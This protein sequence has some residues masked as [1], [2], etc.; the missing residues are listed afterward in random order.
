MLV[1]IKILLDEAKKPFV[2]YVPSNSIVIQGTDKTVEDALNERYT[3]TETDELV[4]TG[5]T[6]TLNSAKAYT[7]DALANFEG[8]ITEAQVDEK[9]NTAKTDLTAAYS[10]ADTTTL[11]SAKSYTDS[12]FD[13]AGSVVANPIVT[14]KEALE[15]QV[16][17]E[18]VRLYNSALRNVSDGKMFT[19]TFPERDI[20]YTDL[21]LYYEYW[22]GGGAGWKITNTQDYSLISGQTCIVQAREADGTYTFTILDVLTNPTSVKKNLKDVLITTC[23]ATNMQYVGQTYYVYDEAL[24]NPTHNQ[25]FI[26]TIPT[27]TQTS[28]V[29]K[30]WSSQQSAYFEGYTLTNAKPIDVSNQKILIQ[31]KVVEDT[32]TFELVNIV[33]EGTV[34]ISDFEQEQEQYTSA[35]TIFYNRIYSTSFKP[36]TVGQLFCLSV[37]KLTEAE[38]YNVIRIDDNSE[39]S[40]PGRGYSVLNAEAKDISGQVVLLRIKTVSNGS[41]LSGTSEIVGIVPKT[42]TSNDVVKKV[43]DF[44]IEKVNGSGNKKYTRFYSTSF[45]PKYVGELFIVQIPDIDDSTYN[46]VILDERSETAYPTRGYS[47]INVTD[48]SEIR[49][50]TV[51]LRVRS[52]R[53]SSSS[54]GVCEIVSVLKAKPQVYDGTGILYQG[55]DIAVTTAIGSVYRKD[56]FIEYN[57]NSGYGRFFGSFTIFNPG[58]AGNGDVTIKLPEGI[59][60]PDFGIGEALYVTVLINSA[61]KQ[62]DA[63]TVQF[64]WDNNLKAFKTNPGAIAQNMIVGFIIPTQDLKIKNV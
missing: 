39:S 51:L 13:D 54:N 15:L 50:S 31:A 19:V 9:I 45:V 11:N 21:R 56:V 41:Y 16:I 38:K 63:R 48:V 17:G 27:L 23:E 25:L 2:P 52:V 58:A 20:S 46:L 57:T 22:Y 55:N 60:E 44:T 35:S 7:D 32:T 64:T 24:R 36:A 33:T 61:T 47:L 3:K 40:L 18:T 29:V 4:N 14:I 26:I 5:D 62:L 10:A 30:F 59:G 49:N 43:E 1:P 6:N 12:K 28:D 37:P 8:G 53:S 34:Y 42:I